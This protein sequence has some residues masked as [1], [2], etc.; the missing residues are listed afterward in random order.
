ML[1]TLRQIVLEVN[2]AQDLQE[3]LEIM[4]RQVSKAIRVEACSV[5]LADRSQNHYKMMASVGFYAKAK[6]HVTIGFNEGL[7]GLVGE[8]E[9]PINIPD[10]QNHPRFCYFPVTGEERYKAF[11][12]VP[13]IHQRKVVGVLVVQQRQKRKFDEGEEAFLITISAQLAGCIAEG[14]TAGVLSSPTALQ[15]ESRSLTLHG[16]P[17]SSGVGIGLGVRIYKPADL[18]SVPDRYCQDIKQEQKRFQKALSKTKKD[19][20]RLH[21]RLLKQL[22]QEEQSLFDAYLKILESD[23]LRLEIE[24]LIN[25]GHWAP[26]ALKK[27]IKGH[28]QKIESVSDPYLRER[29]RD[30]LDLGQRVLA[31]L[32]AESKSLMHYPE[33]TVLLG[34]EVTASNLAEVPEGSLVGIVSAKGSST[35]HVA[36]LARAMGIPT[37]MGVTGLPTF[38]LE[39][40]SV[41]VD[42]YNGAAYV[43]PSEAMLSAF[44]R[45]AEE[46]KELYEGLEELK[47]LPAETPDGHRVPLCVNTG[48]VG[49]VRHAMNIGAEGV[50]LFRSEVAFMIRDRF[51]V[52]Q[53]Q[54]QIY[55]ELL[56]TFAP[57]QVTLRTL[58]VGGDKALPYF[59]IREENPALG[60]RGMR[61]T[62]DHPEIFLVQLRAMV[63]A[64]RGL[65]NLRILF[66]MITHV[67]EI[68]ECVRLLGQAYQEVSDEGLDVVFPE[69]GA[70]IEVPSAVY[71]AGDIAKRVD[72]L[73]VGSNDLTQYILAVDRNNTHVSNLYDP[74]H[75]GVIKALQQVVEA[76]HLHGKMVSICGEMA[77]DPSSVIVLLGL[78]FDM[79]S[80]SAS[81]LPKVKWIIRNFTLARAKELLQDVLHMENVQDIRAYLEYELEQAG[82]GGLVRAGK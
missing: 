32:E 12:G 13:I 15:D 47:N 22:P 41:I 65:E 35:S 36:I 7:V 46:E 5:Y 66:P 54:Y 43:S 2:E 70:M 69:F 78:G 29:A 14:Q 18:F 27:I 82:L 37:V 39:N 11:L 48:F 67:S 50:G 57:K 8:R 9:E 71:Q 77:A 76:G 31:N 60:W 68:E 64:S 79:L 74:L 72:F 28:V 52:E 63:R 21:K 19:I 23:S 20:L 55:R 30:L 10:A 51:P 40:H 75:P 73:S 38:S 44:T 59:P 3:I 25:E 62:L 16:L 58:D 17:V 24:N 45:L 42:G 49:D 56:E 61:I 81:C 4:V 34:D 33:K 1:N 80:M 53:E 26:W 6:G